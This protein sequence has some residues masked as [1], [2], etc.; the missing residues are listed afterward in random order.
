MGEN[1]KIEWATHTLNLWIGC[2]AISPACDHCYAAAYAK[3]VGRDFSQRTRTLSTTWSKALKYQAQAAAFFLEHGHRQRIFVNSL[4]DFF[5][6]EAPQQWRQDFFELARLTPDLDYLLLTKRIGNAP[7]MLPEDWGNGYPNVWI[8]A[9]VPNQP[10]ADRDIPKLLRVRAAIRFLSVEPMLGPLSFV[11]RWV[12]HP[13]P[14]LHENWL[15]ALDWVIAGGESGPEARPTHPEWI[16][17]LRDQCI[18]IGTPFLMKQWGE[19]MP[20]SQMSDGEQDRDEVRRRSTTVLQLD[21]VEEFAFPPGAMTLYRMGKAY[22]GRKLDG[23]TWDEFPKVS[24]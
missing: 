3:R 18:A 7:R 16:R 6:N 5:D 12:N 10:E 14:A 21:G 20:V 4:S 22:S 24:Q 9:T 19:W 23:R 2:E 17:Q 1:T 13:N 8:G 15:E 11:G